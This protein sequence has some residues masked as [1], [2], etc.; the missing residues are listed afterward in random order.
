MASET[1]TRVVTL[2]FDKTDAVSAVTTEWFLGIEKFDRAQVELSTEEHFQVIDA[3]CSKRVDELSLTIDALGDLHWP[4]IVDCVV[5][6]RARALFLFGDECAT[7][8]AEKLT[9]LLRAPHA[10]QEI[11]LRYIAIDGVVGDVVSPITTLTIQ[12]TTD[13]AHSE[14]TVRSLARA[15]PN[16]RHISLGG[17]SNA[18]VVEFLKHSHAAFVSLELYFHK[19]DEKCLQQTRQLLADSPHLVGIKYNCDKVTSNHFLDWMQLVAESSIRRVEFIANFIICDEIASETRA[20]F[21]PTTPMERIWV[22]VREA[23]PHPACDVLLRNV[24]NIE[25]LRELAWSVVSPH[26]P[27]AWSDIE[28][29][30]F[31]ETIRTL[32]VFL[33]T[34]TMPP[35]AQDAMR[36]ISQCRNLTELKL[37]GAIPIVNDDLKFEAPLETLIVHTLPSKAYMVGKF[38][39]AVARPE[40]LVGLN[41]S[42]VPGDAAALQEWL[43]RATNLVSFQLICDTGAELDLS[44]LVALKEL[45]LQIESR[46]CNVEAVVDMV[47]AIPTLET[48]HLWVAYKVLMNA[49]TFEKMCDVLKTRR[50]LHFCTNATSYDDHFVLR[51]LSNRMACR[52]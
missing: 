22:N 9:D 14:E 38:F 20:L 52:V 37:S 17:L 48:L 12:S 13:Y 33:P 5:A 40:T 19:V 28:G 4:R 27:V 49:P 26:D 34:N 31:A 51:K 45:N 2:K 35:T 30:K 15:F 18:L 39:V 50:L 29:L 42:C 3:L 46:D 8:S 41:L 10:L 47:L 43:K 44:V 25:N 16:A 1:P 24:A 36:R 6:T 21:S 7:L 32:H 11:A 23:G